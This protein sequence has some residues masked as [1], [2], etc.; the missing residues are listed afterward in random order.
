ML[1]AIVTALFMTR[2]IQH[3]VVVISRCGMAG[4][5]VQ[6][7]AVDITNRTNGSIRSH[8]LNGAGNFL[9]LLRPYSQWK[10]TKTHDRNGASLTS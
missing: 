1:I 8:L 7:V 6:L 5:T 4:A 3:L 10:Y 2:K 9:T